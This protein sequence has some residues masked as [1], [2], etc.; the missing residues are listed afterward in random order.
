[1]MSLSIGGSLWVGEID[2][3]T[4]F[5]SVVDT[6]SGF[7]GCIDQLTINGEPID[8]ISDAEMAY[9]IREKM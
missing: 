3:V 1:M 8:L 2:D 7:R 6:S 5:S 9:G 4:D